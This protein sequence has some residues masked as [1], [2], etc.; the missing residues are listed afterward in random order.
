[1]VRRDATTPG[2]LLGG[3]LGEPPP[4]GRQVDLP[5]GALVARGLD[6]R[7]ASGDVEIELIAAPAEAAAAHPTCSRARKAWLSCV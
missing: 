1:V 2:G 4:D 6:D 7:H 5:L 3:A